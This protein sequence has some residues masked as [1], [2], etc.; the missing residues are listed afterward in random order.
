MLHNRTKRLGIKEKNPTY[1]INAISLFQ[2]DPFAD[3]P[4]A[5][6][7]FM[8]ANNG[9]LWQSRRAAGIYK[10]GC[11]KLDITEQSRSYLSF[12]H[13]RKLNYLPVSLASDPGRLEFGARSAG[14]NKISLSNALS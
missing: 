8:P 6:D 13:W 12:E 11:R 5:H 14:V 10:N 3:K 7:T 9:R 1:S 2:T 4:G